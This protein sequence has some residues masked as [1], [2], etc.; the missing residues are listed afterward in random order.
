MF[1]LGGG[2][3]VSLLDLAQ[4]STRISF[5]ALTW[6]GFLWQFSVILQVDYRVHGYVLP[7]FPA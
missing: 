5:L 2:S 6:A 4:P 1:A 7:L 3:E